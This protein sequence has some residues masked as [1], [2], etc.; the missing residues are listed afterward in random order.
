MLIELRKSVARK[1]EVAVE[2]VGTTASLSGAVVAVAFGKALLAVALGAISLGIFL[3][4]VNRRHA[5]RVAESPPI[6]GG[7]R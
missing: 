2:V 6:Q 1:L 7:Y 3:R 5:S 4:L